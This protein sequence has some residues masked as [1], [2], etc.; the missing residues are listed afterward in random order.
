MEHMFSQRVNCSYKHA[1][2]YMNQ[3]P[4]VILSLI[5]KFISF[6]AGG[7]AA[8]LLIIAFLDESLLEAHVCTLLT[9]SLKLDIL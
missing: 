6:V 2:E 9:Y 7:F 4:S 5:A 8:I 3:F 1:V